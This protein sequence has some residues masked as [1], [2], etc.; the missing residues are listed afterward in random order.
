MWSTITSYK[1]SIFFMK[2]RVAKD[3][4]TITHCPTDQMLAD[5]F[6]KPLQGALFQRFKAILMGT[7]HINTLYN[8]PPT[9]S[10]TFEERVEEN[11]NLNEPNVVERVEGIS[12]GTRR[13][14]IDTGGRDTNIRT[15]ITTNTTTQKTTTVQKIL[16]ND[17]NSWQLVTKRKKQVQQPNNTS[18][19]RM[20]STSTQSTQ[21]D[22]SSSER[23]E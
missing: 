9:L 22:N 10:T 20:Q 5:F 3:N 16:E 11:T 13:Q 2:D 12:T 4:I 17:R 19:Q 21:K 18:T 15:S 23:S 8:I 1:H 14:N 7:A 6:T